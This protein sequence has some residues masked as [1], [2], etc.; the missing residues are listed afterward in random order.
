VNNYSRFLN[1]YREILKAK[2]AS[3][4]SRVNKEIKNELASSSLLPHNPL[5]RSPENN[6]L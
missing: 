4:N 2:A 6:H 1:F 5:L 3:G